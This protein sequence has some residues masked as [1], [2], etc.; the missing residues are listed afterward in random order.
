[1]AKVDEYKMFQGCVI[2][3]RIPF[4][5]A[6]ARQVFDKLGVKLSEAAFSCCPDPVGFNAVDHESWLAM[7]A[8]NLTIAENDTKQGELFIQQYTFESPS[9]SE[10]RIGQQI[11]NEITMKGCLQSG[12]DGKPIVPVKNV[13]ILL[14]F[15]RTLDQVEIRVGNKIVVSSDCLIKPGET[16]QI[17]SENYTQNIPQPDST[18]YASNNPYP[19]FINS[20]PIVNYCRG[21]GIVTV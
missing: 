4:I 17:L 13:Q 6:S 5:E 14:P 19:S 12:I 1:M 10:T 3:N 20:S 16:P 11:Y 2:G 8:R 9:I 18:I 15:Q 21:F 7:G